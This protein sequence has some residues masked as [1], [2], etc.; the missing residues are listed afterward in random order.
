[1]PSGPSGPSG[2]S[3]TP[4]VEPMGFHLQ[5]SSIVI[6]TY[7]ICVCVYI[8]IYMIHTHVYHTFQDKNDHQN[9]WIHGQ[10]PQPSQRQ[11]GDFQARQAAMLHHT[12]GPGCLFDIYLSV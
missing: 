9:S 5:I 6:Y 1:M 11:L 12:H 4:F 7:I 3:V 10:H 2:G 8:Y